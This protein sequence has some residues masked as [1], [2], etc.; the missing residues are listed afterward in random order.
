MWQL[1]LLAIGAGW[2]LTRDNAGGVG[3]VADNKPSTDNR[4]FFASTPSTAGSRGGGQTNPLAALFGSLAASFGNPG[5][6]PLSGPG[7]STTLPAA[8]G[9][10]SGQAGNSLVP[11]APG[12]P[13]VPSPVH[14]DVASL[15]DPRF[16]WM[17][18][19]VDIA[20]MRDDVSQA[21]ASAGQQG[22]LTPTI[23]EASIGLT[24]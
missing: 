16:Y 6:V 11:A 19:A 18:P 4:P 22:D 7:G 23:V 10:P 24:F 13:G 5:Y 3:I 8:S 15:A 21:M 20:I 14:A 12:T 1:L 2:L 17:Q 9:A